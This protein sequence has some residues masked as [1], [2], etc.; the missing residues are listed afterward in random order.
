MTTRKTR[1]ELASFLLTRALWILF[2]EVTLLSLAFT[3]AP[4]GGPETGGRTVI[5]LQ[6]LYVIGG[7]MVVLA[8]AQFLGRRSCH[9]LG[10]LIVLGHN[11]L[12]A[13][14]P[15]RN[16]LGPEPPPWV[17]L[18]TG[19]MRTTEHFQLETSCG[20]DHPSGW[21]SPAASDSLG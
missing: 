15:A 16:A 18:H 10:L 19:R 1:R 2:V 12:D 21:R 9:L 8:A 11:V 4:F 13:F 14:W 17:S 7:S 6:T 20:L 5:I 3:F